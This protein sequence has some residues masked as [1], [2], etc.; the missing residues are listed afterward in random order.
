MLNVSS[1]ETAAKIEQLNQLTANISPEVN[2]NA[3][4]AC[5]HYEELN[6]DVWKI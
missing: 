6:F 4:K 5:D 2:Q 3:A 1:K